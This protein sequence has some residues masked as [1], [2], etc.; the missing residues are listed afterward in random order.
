MNV[1][2]QLPILQVVLPLA[3][4]PLAVLLR[5]RLGAFVLVLAATWAAFTISVLL[6]LQVGESGLITYEL[7]SWPPPWGIEYRVDALSSLMLMLVSG[8]A[9]VVLPYSRASIERE[10]RQDK[11]YLF[12]ALFALCLS[13][14]LGITITGDAFN[15]FVFLEISS[16]SSYAMIALGKDRRSLVAAYQY[17]IMGTI[18]ATFIVIGIGLLYIKTGTLNLADLGVRLQA[19]TSHRPVLAA[20]A[21]LTVGI[22][23]KLAL[24]PLHQWLPNAYAY[25]PS[26]VSAFLAATATKV[27]VYALLR[28]YFSVFGE[29]AIFQRLPMEELMLVLALAAMFVASTVAIFQDNLK[30]LFAYSSVA[31]IGYIVLGISFDSVTGLTATIVHL[32]NH[33][34]TKGGLFLLLGAVI[35]G[36]GGVTLARV[37]GIGRVMPLTSFG[38]VLCGLSLIG[39]PGTAGFVSKW[40]LILAALEKGQWWLVFLIVLSSLLAVAYVW[41]FV[42]AAYFHAPRADLA[43]VREAP[44]ALALPAWILV[45]ATLWFGFDTSI[46][47]GS[48]SRAAAQ[49][50]GI[51]P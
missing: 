13:G 50:L 14:L 40:Y 29:T 49:L 7:G 19:M 1:S 3:S 16:L 27:S 30:R 5:D 18:G 22:S 25:A 48:A 20:L 26:V 46:T 44:L 23:L 9:A 24:F 38:I 39:V 33:A 17:L 21:F 34:V 8:V 10:I 43:G 2:E 6:W 47:V 41:R 12:Y 51:A 15:L 36:M 31:Q 32:V 28:F 37:H 11:H 35:G 4:A 45:A 42:E